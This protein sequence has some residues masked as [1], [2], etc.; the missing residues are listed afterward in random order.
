VEHEIRIITDRLT[1][2]PLCAK[3]IPQAVAGLND[4]EV[5]KWLTVVP[6]PYG[7]PDGD[8]FLAYLEGRP[9]FE[10]LAI[11]APEGMVGVVGIGD[12]LGYWLARSAHAK[13]YMTEAAGA[14]VDHYFSTQEADH[15][16]S[17]YF[18]GNLAS[19]NVLGKLGFVPD[20]EEQVKSRAQ[21]IEV[22]LKKVVLTR[23]AWGARHG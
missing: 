9:A 16:G 22:T 4:Y 5:S 23:E 7:A 21:G 18:T 1:L 3:D 19:A 2:R 11:I 10:A 15:L 12:T 17:G 8:E 20:G 6:Y 14:L 13:G